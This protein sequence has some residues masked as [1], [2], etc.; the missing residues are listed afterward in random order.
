MT[1]AINAAVRFTN[2]SGKESLFNASHSDNG[3]LGGGVWSGI[4]SGNGS[5]SP[6]SRLLST[7]RPIELRELS[8]DSRT[9]YRSRGCKRADAIPA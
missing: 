3:L 7:D 8:E 6:K 9:I 1:R 4:W 2:I 5:C